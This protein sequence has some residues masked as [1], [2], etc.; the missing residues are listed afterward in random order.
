MKMTVEGVKTTVLVGICVVMI[1]VGAPGQL[2]AQSN[3]G[4]VCGGLGWMPPTEE[5]LSEAT[6]DCDALVGVLAEG[7]ST[8]NGGAAGG[9]GQASPLAASTDIAT[10][11]W[12]YY[13]WAELDTCSD[14]Y[15]IPV[16][17]TYAILTTG[18]DITVS[19]NF[20]NSSGGCGVDDFFGDTDNSKDLVVHL[21]GVYGI[22]NDTGDS[23]C[24]V[25]KLTAAEYSGT[26]CSGS[27]QR[28]PYSDE[29]EFGTTSG[30]REFAYAYCDDK[31]DC[32]GSWGDSC[33]SD[34]HLPDILFVD[35]NLSGNY[36][37]EVAVQTRICDSDCSSNCSEWD[38]ERGGCFYVNWE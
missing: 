34:W 1:C 8:E 16:G 18:A 4:P 38:T 13:C 12:R 9:G 3:E 15:R 27:V 21:E 22:D 17:L 31:A 37:Y 30:G 7:A 10:V 33:D 29:V 11:G 14:A 5:E 20:V 6:L 28:G 2:L 26:S 23:A 24:F 35:N 32:A 19:D 25:A 36:S